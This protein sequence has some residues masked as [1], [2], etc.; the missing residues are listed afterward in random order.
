VQES[1]T[2][3]VADMLSET[4]QTEYVAFILKTKHLCVEILGVRYLVAET[5][6]M[7]LRGKFENLLKEL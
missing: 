5:N 7:V 3:E 2:I 4:L 1:L 6:T